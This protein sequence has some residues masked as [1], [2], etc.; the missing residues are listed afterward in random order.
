M[1]SLLAEATASG[2]VQ[3]AWR[4]RLGLG[5]DGTT[6]AQKRRALQG[7]VCVHC[8]AGQRPRCTASC[9]HTLSTLWPTSPGALGWGWGATRQGPHNWG[10]THVQT[11]SQGRMKTWPK[12][13]G[14]FA[15]GLGSPA[16]QC[17]AWSFLPD[18]KAS[19]CTSRASA[20]E[21]WPWRQRLPHCP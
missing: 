2:W 12:L 1:G 20:P 16:L 6:G 3:R 21:Q 18:K 5:V 11:F 10:H 13:S 7:G 17:A 4:S 9:T 19:P 15:Q 14:G 8:A